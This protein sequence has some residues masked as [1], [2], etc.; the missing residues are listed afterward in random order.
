MQEGSPGRATSNGLPR[1]SARPYPLT[2]EAGS[3]GLCAERQVVLASQAG[4]V[5][6]AREF[7]RAALQT[8]RIGTLADAATIVVSELVT[9]AILH[10]SCNDA[11]EPALVL[12]ALRRTGDM[13]TIITTDGNTRPPELAVPADPSA[14]NGRGLGVVNALADQW[15]W[16]IL[17]VT[18]KAVWAT[19]RL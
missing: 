3:S 17:S 16:T 1:R 15:G 10:G 11:D 14:E 6:E 4:S 19:L 18:A 13:V 12:L 2:L 8:W 5:G 7:T 9:N